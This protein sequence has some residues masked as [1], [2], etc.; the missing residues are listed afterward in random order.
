MPG[1][2]GNGSK[3]D[4]TD[5]LHPNLIGRREEE[6]TAHPNRMFTPS[7]DFGN[8]GNKIVDN[9]ET[10]IAMGKLLNFSDERQAAACALALGECE[11]FLYDSNGKENKEVKAIQNRIKY[12]ATL[13]CSV[14]GWGV[15]QYKQTAIGVATNTF[16]QAGMKPLG[17][18]IS[19]P[20]G[21]SRNEGSRRNEPRKS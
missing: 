13:Q 10:V 4:N 17:V 19:R 11:L 5:L 21:D 16:T 9:E 2:N 18:P 7:G 14:K 3:V 20:G 8:P 15:D 6:N 12:R 1:N